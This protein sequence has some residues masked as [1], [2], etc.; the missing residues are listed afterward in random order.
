MDDCKR[1]AVLTPVL[2]ACGRTL[3]PVALFSLCINLLILTVPVFMI[4][5]FDRV[6]VSRSHDTLLILLG[7]AVVAL[8]VMAALEIVRSRILVR[9]GAWLG[10]R[11]GPPLMRAIFERSNR[12]QSVGGGGLG[13][14]TQVQAFLTGASVFALFDTPW[15]PV[16]LAV[17]FLLH[18]I[19]GW[20][21]TGGAVGLLVLALINQVLVGRRLRRANGA[22]GL[23]NRFGAAA[24]RQSDAIAALGMG[25]AVAARWSELD[26]RVQTDHNVANDRAGT[27]MALGRFVRFGLQLIVLATAAALVIAH[28]LTAGGMIAAGIILARALAP[29]ERSIEVWRAVVLFRERMRR[30]SANLESGPGVARTTRLPPPVEPVLEAKGVMSWPEG[31]SEPIFADV[32]FQIRPGQLLGLTGPMGAGKSTLARLLVGLDRPDRGH[33]RLDGADVFAWDSRELGAH[34]GYLPQ[35]AALLPGSV[36]D[37]IARFS[38]SPAEA[39]IAAATEVGIHKA[40]LALPSGYDTMVGDG[41]LPLPGGLMQRIGLAR[42][43]FGEPWLVVLDEP[44]SNMDGDGVDAMLKALDRLKSRG[45]A[46]VIVSHRPS[47]LARTDQVLLLDNGRA[48]FASARKQRQLKLLSGGDLPAQL[49]APAKPTAAAKKRR[50]G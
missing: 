11:L 19:L 48:R 28:E 32:G 5:L 42:A 36:K 17:I 40:I 1:T 3:V 20:I 4:Q 2:R 16:F 25:D 41:G 12:G 23:A 26:W 10:D 38:D 13:D 7:A 47:I 45:A 43:L 30:I 9:M 18:P 14:L 27:V 6:L 24:T 29:V 37:N 15:V 35:T 33:V 8:G 50:A 22:Q 21:A 46:T 39:V 44:Y 34:V 31:R 49:A